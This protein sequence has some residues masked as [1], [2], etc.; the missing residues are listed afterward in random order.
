MAVIKY[1]YHQ[2]QVDHTLFMKHNGSRNTAI[3]VYV[4]EIVVTGN[5]AVEMNQL[6]HQ[7][8]Q[9]FEIKYLGQLHY[10]LGIEVAK[11]KKGLFISQRKYTFD[12]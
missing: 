8:A 7:F 12:L 9:E 4:H 1:G 10:V 5:D 2:S 6:K 11:S 3:I